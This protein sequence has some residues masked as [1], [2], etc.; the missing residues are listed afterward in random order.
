MLS[1]VII[2]NSQNLPIDYAS[3]LDCFK[4]GTEYN[5]TN[6]I[7][8]IIGKN[9]CGKTTLLKMIYMYLLCSN[10]QYTKLPSLNN[11]EGAL[12]LGKLFNED[13]T[14]KDGIKIKFD[15]LGVA[16]H[17]IMGNEIGNENA[18]E[19]INNALLFMDSKSCSNGESTLKSLG[20]LFDFSFK[21]KKVNFPLIEIKE[22]LDKENA[23]EIWLK[24]LNKLFQY[25]MDN[26]IPIEAKD[27]RYTFLI[28]E[29]D[30]NLDISNIMQIYNILSY[31]KDMTQLICVIHNP[32]IIYKLSKLDYVNIIEMSEG[33]LQEIKDVIEKL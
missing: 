9:G 3:K 17:Y 10:T 11:I 31:E 29:P 23:N 14:L 12:E 32:I 27:F 20:N 24:R 6:G 1:K 22:I 33:Y 21:N 16:Y 30:R 26:R 18:L 13:E 2:E 7:N 8:I 4:N 25:Y 28:D 19:S 5:F 15:Y